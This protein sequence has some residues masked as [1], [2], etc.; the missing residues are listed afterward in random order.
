MIMLAKE[1]ISFCPLLIFAC[2]SGRVDFL[3]GAFASCAV[4]VF[5]YTGYGYSSPTL[6]SAM[7]DLV[8]VFA[9]ILAF[10][11]RMEN[12]NP[13]LQSILAKIIGTVVSIKGVQRG[14]NYD[15]LCA[16]ATLCLS[17]LLIVQTWIM[18]DF[19]EL[20]LM[21]ICCGFVVILSTIVALIAEHNPTAWVLRPD[22]ELVAILYSAI[23]VVTMRNVVNAWAC[24]KKGPVYVSMFNPLGMV[25][26][27]GMGFIFLGD[28]LYLESMIRCA[29][30]AASRGEDGRRWY[31]Q[32]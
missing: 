26:A 30:G 25:M 27:I 19:P 12:L 15:L 20:I 5:M 6:S 11:S 24:S 2:G 8:P 31:T 22:I 23:F 3:G 28:V 4:Q 17:L 7:V 10:I 13:K 32:K 16:A 21:T 18:K 1:M 29:V 9:F 14:I